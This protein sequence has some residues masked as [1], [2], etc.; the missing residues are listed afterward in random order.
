[1]AVGEGMRRFTRRT[2]ILAAVGLVVAV[3]VGVSLGGQGDETPAPPAVLNHIAHRNRDATVEAAAKMK[4][5]SEATARAADAR[6]NAADTAPPDV[7][8]GQQP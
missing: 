6:A 1:M 8:N 4:V 7:A 3:I 5:E 2:W